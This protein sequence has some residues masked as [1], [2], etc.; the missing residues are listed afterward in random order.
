MKMFAPWLVALSLLLAP[1]AGA[2]DLASIPF[3]ELVKHSDLVVSARAVRSEFEGYQGTPR[4]FDFYE[5][6]ITYAFAVDERLRG[7]CSET[8]TVSFPAVIELITLR[9]SLI[10]FLRK[11]GDTWKLTSD[12]ERACWVGERATKVPYDTSVWLYELPSYWN[13]QYCLTDL[14]P[15]LLRTEYLSHTWQG[16]RIERQVTFVDKKLT[17][18]H[19][20]KILSQMETPP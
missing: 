20:K 16:G 17:D 2:R 7:D 19:L 3:A 13:L 6:R 18:R 9:E 11:E 10:L 8:I 5:A 4:G 1:V 14:P 15:R 12:D